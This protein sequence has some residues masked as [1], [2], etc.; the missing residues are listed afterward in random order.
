MHDRTLLTQWHRNRDGEAF[1]ELTRKYASMTYATALRILRNPH[2]AEDVAQRCFETLATNRRAPGDALGPWLHRVAVNAALD[3]RK[4][5]TRRAIRETSY[6]ETQPQAATPQW[7]DVYPLVD[8]AIA[9]LPEKLRRAVVGHYLEQ[10]THAELAA[11]ESISREAMTQRVHRGVEQ[12]RTALRK[13]GIAVPAAA[14]A[15]MLGS[16]LARAAELPG[17]LKVRLGQIAVSGVTVYGATGL[18]SGLLGTSLAKATL[19]ALVAAIGGGAWYWGNTPESVPEATIGSAGENKAAAPAMAAL[20]TIDTDATPRFASNTPAAVAPESEQIHQPAL[21]G[22]VYDTVTG[23]GIVGAEVSV[24]AGEFREKVLTEE[25][26]H[27]ALEEL[28]PGEFRVTCG[29]ANGYYIPFE[30]GDEFRDI[31][32]VAVT[33][34]APVA[35]IDFGMKRGESISGR[36]V[37]S[38]GNPVA[39]ATITGGTEAV[40]YHFIHTATSE[41]D[42]SFIV[43]GFP[44]TL[45]AWVWAETETDT[46]ASTGP[47]TLP[48]PDAAEV[49]VVLQAKTAIRGKVVYSTGKSVA[50]ATVYPQYNPHVGVRSWEAESDAQG[51]FELANLPAG[52]LSLHASDGN[53][54]RSESMRFQLQAGIDHEDIELLCPL[55]DASIA[56]HVVDAH[57]RRLSVTRITCMS[58]DFNASIRTDKQGSFVL[59]GLTPGIYRLEADRFGEYVTAVLP[60]VATGSTEVE[61]VLEAFPRVAGRVV[62]AETNEPITRFTLGAPAGAGLITH[63]QTYTPM[64]NDKGEYNVPLFSLGENIVVARVEGYALGKVTVLAEKPGELLRDV[65]IRMVRQAD[66]HG[67]VRDG[68]GRGLENAVIYS[69]EP[70][71]GL[72]SDMVACR[73]AADGSFVLP[74]SLVAHEFLMVHAVESPAIKV[75]LTPE[76]FA[77]DSID[78]VMSAGGSISVEIYE[79]G[80]LSDRGRAYISTADRDLGFQVQ[81]VEQKNGDSLSALSAGRYTISSNLDLGV[82]RPGPNKNDNLELAENENATPRLD[83]YSGS[84]TLRGMIDVEPDWSVTFLLSF[85]T[86]SGIQF[87]ALRGVRDEYTFPELPEGTAHLNARFEL[88]DRRG[89][90]EQNFTLDFTNGTTI[91]QDFNFEDT[92][93]IGGNVDE[94]SE[95]KNLSIIAFVGEVSPQLLASGDFSAMPDRF[96]S[97]SVESSGNFSLPGLKD[98][99]YTLAAIASEGDETLWLAY[100][101]VTLGDEDITVEL[102]PLP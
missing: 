73:T 77:G 53:M 85:K 30:R 16:E 1:H 69:G 38:G 72:K 66:L 31:R 79:N 4:R 51:N 64:E 62:D 11:A 101:V 60:E 65:E 58:A 46:S 42:G 40:N 97:I 83:F 7:D 33:P 6:Q 21:S 8:E 74:A 2:D 70:I 54:S 43:S 37:D 68:S 50:G 99:T 61:I 44:P 80:E 17:A 86:A 78:I 81:N 48:A 95:H 34:G 26:G 9:A 71:A 35:N 94:Y 49:K 15:A 63:P 98:S 19:F 92:L 55:G 76:H 45:E 100:A 89:V 88:P 93:K 36:V 24:S 12:V 14:L 59:T 20:D 52:S 18:L 56:G 27:Y 3:W 5:E 13:R 75:P 67:T 41:K 10:R 84:A 57:G 96:G 87:Y 102:Q 29:A 39:G 90:L 28:S 82:D 91:I 47:L 25:E 32:K 22:R 23:K